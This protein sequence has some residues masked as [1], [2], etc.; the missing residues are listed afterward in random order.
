M[1]GI[2]LVA[3]QGVTF[4]EAASMPCLALTSAS[5]TVIAREHSHKPR[6]MTMDER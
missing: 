6:G 1:Q 2:V 5:T 4:N 3:L